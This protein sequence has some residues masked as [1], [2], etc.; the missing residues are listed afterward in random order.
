MPCIIRYFLL[1][2]VQNSEQN[3]DVIKYVIALHSSRPVVFET[4]AF[5]NF[6]LA[7]VVIELALKKGEVH[8]V[9]SS[10]DIT[11]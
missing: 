10:Y 6:C 4:C 3:I 1:C 11:L 8:Y 9:S 5:T 2:A 7:D